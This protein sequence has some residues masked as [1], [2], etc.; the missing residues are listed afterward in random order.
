MRSN[1]NDIAQFIVNQRQRK[2][3]RASTLVF[4]CTGHW[5]F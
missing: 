3:E 2:R 5:N 4:V 1:A